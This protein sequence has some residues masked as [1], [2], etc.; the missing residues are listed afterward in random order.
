MLAGDAANLQRDKVPPFGHQHGR[1]ALPR[2]NQG[3]GVVRR[4]GNDHIGAGHVLHHA[5]LRDLALQGADTLANFGAA[6]RFLQFVAHFLSRHAQLAIEIPVFEGHVE[7]DD[8]EQHRAQRQQRKEQQIHGARAGHPGREH[9]EIEHLA[10][11]QAQQKIGGDEQHK[12]LDQR[13]EQFQQT[14]GGKQAL[15]PF[16]RV[17]LFP[18][19]G[20]GLQAEG[21]PAHQ[22]RAG[23]SGHQG[24][25][26]KRQQRQQRVRR[27]AH[28][29]HRHGRGVEGQRAIDAKA[30]NTE[31]KQPFHKRATEGPKRRARQQQ[32]KHGVELFGARHL[33]FAARFLFAALAGRLGAFL[34]GLFFGH[35]RDLKRARAGSVPDPGAGS[36]AS[37]P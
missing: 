17:E 30:G 21:P 7:G 33:T 31:R 32:R 11:E 20:H 10:L 2:I 24:H 19:E 3:H 34:S 27:Q 12:K 37:P 35:G 28:K 8:K 29:V 1:A 36:A 23:E 13:L 26:K 9:T 18:F 22:Q 6:L 4:V 15:E 25:G 14:L 5:S 16:D